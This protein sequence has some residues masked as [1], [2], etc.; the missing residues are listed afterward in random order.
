MFVVL[1]M[2]IF[3]VIIRQIIN[4]R[5]RGNTQ[6]RF[7]FEICCTNVRLSLFLLHLLSQD[8]VTVCHYVYVYLYI[9]IYLFMYE[10]TKQCK[11][12]AE[13]KDKSNTSTSP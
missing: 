9:F 10:S 11:V 13:Q 7:M 3:T 2:K 6:L 8:I 12:D 1:I 5:L 4:L